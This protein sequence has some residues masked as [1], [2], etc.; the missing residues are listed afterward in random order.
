LR[1]THAS[2][3]QQADP[4]YNADSTVTFDISLPDQTY[5][6]DEQ[7]LAFYKNLLHQ[8]ESIAGVKQVGLTSNMLGGWQSNYY[9]EGAPIPASGQDIH[10]EYSRISPNLFRAMGIQ[11]L[12]GRFF[13][14]HDTR[15]ASSVV[16]VDEKFANKWW[17]DESALGKR[18]QLH[19]NSPD[20]NS[21]WSEVIGVVHHVKH[22]G[23]DNFSRESIYLCMYQKISDYMKLVVR[24]QGDPLGL[25]VPIQRLVSQIDPDVPVYN[26]QTLQAISMERSFVRRLTTTVLG[27]FALTALLLAALGIYGVMAYS[28]SRR[29]NEIGIRIALG[30]CMADIVR[31]VLRQGARLALIGIVI[32]LAVS[33]VLSRLISTFLFG[34]TG[35]DPITFVLVV[36]V[37][38]LSALI[39]C[40][41]P[42]RRAARID[43]MEALRYE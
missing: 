42:A 6:T 17:P 5:G 43:P 41:I 13:N 20:P 9:V 38:T 7:K 23:V 35:Y 33:L 8:A 37:L 14:D 32:G 19:H 18:I 31:M 24:T 4:G 10:A 27:V 2:H 22:Y 36:A 29:T 28:V 15:D 26:V 40:Y 3:Y 21:P 11:L 39:A 30:A 12:E 25:V 16:V 34:V 1:R